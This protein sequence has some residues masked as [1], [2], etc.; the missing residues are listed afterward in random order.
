MKIKMAINRRTISFGLLNAILFC[1]CASSK[2]GA[3][4]D[5]SQTADTRQVILVP[6]VILSS[7]DGDPASQKHD[8]SPEAVPPDRSAD[9]GQP[10]HSTAPVKL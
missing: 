8:V 6:V 1:G 7:P 4:A 5:G 3:A 2:Q 10:Q 9:N